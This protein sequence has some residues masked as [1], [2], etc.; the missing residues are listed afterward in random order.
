MPQPVTDVLRTLQQYLIGQYA[1]DRGGCSR[2]PNVLAR[3]LAYGD[4]A[5]VRQVIEDIGEGKLPQLGQGTLRLSEELGQPDYA[6]QS[7]G[8]EYPA[9]L[10]QTNPGYPWALAG[11]HMSMRTYMVLLMEFFAELREKVL[12][13]FDA[14]LEAN[15]PTPPT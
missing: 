8:V 10:P 6:M 12:D 3:G 13:K 4:A 11:G 14:L 15:L 5:A 7:K 1:P 2:H 9:Y